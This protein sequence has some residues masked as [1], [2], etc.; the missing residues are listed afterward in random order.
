MWAVAETDLD[1]LTVM[2]NVTTVAFAIGG[3]C[4]SSAVNIWVGYGGASSLTEVGS[5]LYYKCSFA[6]FAA[7]IVFFAIG[8]YFHSKKGSLWEKIKAESKIVTLA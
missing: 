6:A 4:L 5:F 7:S 3:F 2:T 1:A 8:V